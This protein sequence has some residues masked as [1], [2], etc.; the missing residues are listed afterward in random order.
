MAAVCGYSSLSIRFLSKASAMSFSAGEL[1]TE[2]KKH[3]PGFEVLYAPDFR[4]AI[5][6]SWPRSLDDRAAREEWGWK[7]KYDLARM[8]VDM[9]AKLREKRRAGNP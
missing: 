9:L 7:P 5:A 6:D 2:I 3:V 8:T 1:A 4:Q